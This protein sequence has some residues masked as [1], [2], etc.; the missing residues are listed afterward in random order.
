M[1]IYSEI[2]LKDFEFW[3]P[4][5]HVRNVLDDDDDMAQIES[6]LDDTAPSEGYSETDINDIFAYDPDF[7]A[8][9]LGYYDWEELE[10]GRNDDED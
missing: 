10:E 7:I 9:C 5:L 8:G 3:G 6:C 4:A 1:K 2:S